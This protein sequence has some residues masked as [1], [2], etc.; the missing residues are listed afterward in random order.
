MSDL[1]AALDR[2][3]AAATAMVAAARAL[4]SAHADFQSATEA[5]ASLVPA[6][7]RE[8]GDHAEALLRA[9]PAGLAFAAG[10]HWDW[11]ITQNDL[12]VKNAGDRVF[13]DVDRSLAE[14][15]SAGYAGGTAAAAFGYEFTQELWN[16]L[17]AAPNHARADRTDPRCVGSFVR[18]VNL[19]AVRVNTLVAEAAAKLLGQVK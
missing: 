10:H 4:S 14:A 1:S 7:A 8:A 12:V 15:M 3:V 18:A 6:T 11:E 13:A 17:L 19:Q 2:R 9:S 16:M 5:L